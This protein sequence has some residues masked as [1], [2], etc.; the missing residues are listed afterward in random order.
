M[1]LC[2]RK[3]SHLELK[4]PLGKSKVYNYLGSVPKNSFTA[5]ANPVRGSTGPPTLSGVA[6]YSNVVGFFSGS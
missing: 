5:L 3:Q 4:I 6:K 2:P 1:F